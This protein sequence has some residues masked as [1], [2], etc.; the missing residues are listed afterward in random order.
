MKQEQSRTRL[1][2]SCRAMCW[3]CAV[4]LL[5]A[6]VAV[7][8]AA[9]PPAAISGFQE[10][11]VSSRGGGEPQV[12]CNNADLAPPYGTLD[13]S[14]ILAY[15]SAFGNGDPVAD[16]APP[17]EEL[18]FS[19]VIGF[20]QTFGNAQYQTYTNVPLNEVR[21]IGPYDIAL[22]GL[23]EVQPDGQ[24]NGSIAVDIT[25]VKLPGAPASFGIQ[26]IDNKLI[27]DFAGLVILLN[28]LDYL[29]LLQQ[30]DGEPEF[31][32]EIA[33]I[34]DQV[35]E[36]VMSPDAANALPEEV[37]FVMAI[38]ALGQNE[39]WQQ[40]ISVARCEANRSPGF[41]CKAAA[42]GCG[43]AITAL[44]TAGCIA[45]T[46]A[47]A[48]GTTVTLGGLA[49]PCTGLIALCAGGVFAG[50]AAAYELCLAAWD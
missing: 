19:D 50:G 18:D 21:Q 13:F 10:I 11:D 39:Q 26:I 29:N 44:A 31:P 9:I 33:P 42:I 27:A 45:L 22:N 38:T 32:I 47:C 35:G 4:Q 16:F 8:G 25:F 46:G 28:N 1:S 37:L 40:N 48:A 3:L 20:L 30:F 34:L 7:A 15:L 36:Y 43:A 14:D 41:W 23:V 2:V 17:P 12:G 49:I 6:P 24:A 5:F